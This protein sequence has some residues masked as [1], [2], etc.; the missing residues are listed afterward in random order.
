MSLAN[1]IFS[2]RKTKWLTRVLQI[3]STSGRNNIYSKFLANNKFIW[4]R[5]FEPCLLLPLQNSP[6]NAEATELN[7]NLFAIEK[8]AKIF[9]ELCKICLLKICFRFK[10]QLTE[11]NCRDESP[12][13]RQFSDVF[14]LSPKPFCCRTASSPDDCRSVGTMLA[15][16]SS[17]SWTKA[18][19]PLT[20]GSG[21]PLPLAS[22]KGTHRQSE[23]L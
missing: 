20:A 14:A 16:G 1:R 23:P 10:S 18:Y 4:R 2:F 15:V 6:F 7:F 17:E 8:E 19:R 9:A 13:G 11:R 5:N 21:E 3:D 22:H 12:N